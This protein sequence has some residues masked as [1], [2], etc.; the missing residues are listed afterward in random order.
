M[1]IFTTQ[2]LIIVCRHERG[3]S[4]RFRVFRGKL[5]AIELKCCGDLLNACR[6]IYTLL[7]NGRE[8]GQLESQAQKMPPILT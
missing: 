3:G 1:R 7:V 8:V 4:T 5:P 2:D 6:L